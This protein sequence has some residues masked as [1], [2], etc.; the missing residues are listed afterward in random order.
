ML[1]INQSGIKEVVYASDKYNGELSF[2]ASRRLFDL[3]GIKY[4]VYDGRLPEIAYRK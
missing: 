2:Q 1:G 3:A 4:R